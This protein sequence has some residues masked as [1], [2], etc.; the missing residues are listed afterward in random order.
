VR[1]S[2]QGEIDRIVEMP[3]SRPSACAF[4]GPDY[5]TLFVTTASY[6]MTPSELAEDAQAGSLYAIRLEDVAGLPADLFD[7]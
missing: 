6:R 3:T 5:K 7:A 2:P 1:Y 4:G